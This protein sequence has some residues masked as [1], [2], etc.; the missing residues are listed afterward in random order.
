MA[1]IDDFRARLAGGGARPSQFKVM[2][3]FPSWVTAGL[4]AGFAG[5][6]LIKTTSLPASIITPIDVPFRG[7]IAKIAGEK[8]FANWNVTVLNDNDFLI[9]NALE[10]WSQ[11]ILENSTTVGRMAPSSY[12]S[13]MVVQQLDRNDFVLKEYKFF[14]C[15]P[16][17]VAE[18]GLDFGAT[19]QIEEFQVEFSIDYW[20]S[21]A[22]AGQQAG[23]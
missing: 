9:R 18:I 4:S 6:F 5:E 19:T 1:R 10:V 8:Q 17:N 14:N 21:G 3:T 20:L 15:F 11:G 7:R 22:Q 23:R 12:T 13:D 16:Q 2:L